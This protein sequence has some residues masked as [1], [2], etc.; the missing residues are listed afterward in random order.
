MPA[1][2]LATKLI[3]AKVVIGVTENE[4]LTLPFPRNG[5]RKKRGVERLHY[6]FR[7]I[8]FNPP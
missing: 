6:L 8:I 4:K 3:L 7:R 1:G 2:R 5:S